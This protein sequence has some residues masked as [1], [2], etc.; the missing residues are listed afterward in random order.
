MENIPPSDA[1][2]AFKE[3]NNQRRQAFTSRITRP[4]MWPGNNVLGKLENARKRF[5]A[6][7]FFRLLPGKYFGEALPRR[8]P[9]DLGR[10]RRTDAQQGNIAQNEW[11]DA[12]R[13]I[14][15]AD[16]PTRSHCAV[17][18]R[19]S[20][21]GSQRLATDVVHAAS[22]SFRGK[23]R[24]RRGQLCARDTCSVRPGSS[25]NPQS[26]AVPWTPPLCTLLAP[27]S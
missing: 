24:M 3:S 19:F 26:L 10:P 5:H 14:R 2:G 22:P 18:C 16:H 12:E 7:N 8:Q 9:W 25:T 11:E 6:R 20:Q 13:H 17:R 21:H 4:W 27:K 1:A 15:S 23:R